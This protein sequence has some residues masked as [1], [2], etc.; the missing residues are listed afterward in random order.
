MFVH[1]FYN[2]VVANLDKRTWVCHRPHGSLL[3]EAVVEELKKIT[4][5]VRRVVDDATSDIREAA[6]SL[7]A[8]EVHALSR[9]SSLNICAAVAVDTGQTLFRGVLCVLGQS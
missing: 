3:D 7:G 1:N 8:P 9:R 6:K 2:K 4:D 5:N